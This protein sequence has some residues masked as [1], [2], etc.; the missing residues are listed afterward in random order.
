M[1]GTH[2]S[3][4]RRRTLQWLTAAGGAALTGVGMPGYVFAQ[5][6]KGAIVIGQANEV[7]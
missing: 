5:E 2:A 3:L 4:S 1:S 7:R 6:R